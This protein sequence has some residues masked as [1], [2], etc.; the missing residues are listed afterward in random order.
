[1]RRLAGLIAIAAVSAACTSSSSTS[2][3]RGNIAIA[4]DPAQLIGSWHVAAVGEAK[5]TS[6]ILA[7][8]LRLFRSCGMLEGGWSADRYGDFVGESWGGDQACFIGAHPNSTVAWLSHAVTYRIDGP[9]RVLL[10]AAHRV[11]A[12]LSPGARPTPNPNILPSLASPPVKDASMTARLAEPHSLA[13][14]LS[15]AT[16]N[17]VLGRWKAAGRR[18]S[19]SEGFVAFESGGRWK[20]SD[21]CNAWGGRYEVGPYGELISVSGPTTLIGCLVGSPAPGWVGQAG[22]VALVHG[23]LVLFDRSGRQLGTLIRTK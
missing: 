3:H 12:R 7:D 17:D 19:K 1:M 11:V 10:D 5:G 23:D 21:G 2:G 14:G 20:G 18:V 9:D 16:S 15:A 4:G 22:R 6:L 8:D 13:A